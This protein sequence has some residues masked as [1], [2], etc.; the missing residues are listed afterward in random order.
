MYAVL[1]SDGDNVPDTRDN[2]IFDYNPNQEDSDGDGIGN[3]CE[4]PA[5]T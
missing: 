4:L 5:P 3:A 2:C 1:D